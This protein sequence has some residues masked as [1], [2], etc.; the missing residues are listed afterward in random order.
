MNNKQSKLEKGKQQYNQ[1]GNNGTINNT[2]H[3]GV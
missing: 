1:Q 3:H 2:N